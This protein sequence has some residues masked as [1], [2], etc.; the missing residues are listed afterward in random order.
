MSWDYEIYLKNQLISLINDLSLDLKVE[1]CEEQMFAKIKEYMPKTIYCVIKYL[2][3]TIQFTSVIRPVQIMIMSEANQLTN[4]KI[5]FDALAN[6]YNWMTVIENTTYV[7]QQYSS[8]VVLSNF[9]DVSYTFRSVL[10]ISA[11]LI[12]MENVVDVKG[13]FTISFD[14]TVNGV[15]TV[16]SVLIDPISQQFQYIASGDTQPIGGRKIS[17]TIKSVSTFSLSLIVAPTNNDF[18]QEC[19]KI[20]KG[21]VSGNKRFS[22]VFT[23]GDIDFNINMVLTS[24]NHNSAKNEIPGISIGLMQ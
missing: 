20:S 2:A 9:N 14:E 19:I 12:E 24:F 23:L 5:L 22:V 13:G 18:I 15:T 7:K 8:P 1:V 10:Y 21:I 11:T 6:N 4:V 16:K 17:E 3:T